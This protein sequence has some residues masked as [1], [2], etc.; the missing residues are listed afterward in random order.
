MVRDLRAYFILYVIKI[1]L[2]CPEKLNFLVFHK[3]QGGAQ[4]KF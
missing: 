1:K 4:S 3:D 2:M